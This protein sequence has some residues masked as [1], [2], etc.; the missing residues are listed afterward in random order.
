MSFV[1]WAFFTLLFL[2]TGWM[3][4][5]IIEEYIKHKKTCTT[6]KWFIN[7]ACLQVEKLSEKEKEKEI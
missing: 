2:L 7:C 6:N 1:D 3:F 5:M 4:K